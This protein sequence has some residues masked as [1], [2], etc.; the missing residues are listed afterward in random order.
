VGM[1]ERLYGLAMAVWF[2]RYKEV[3]ERNV[4]VINTGDRMWIMSPIWAKHMDVD[5]DVIWRW[6][7]KW[8]V[9]VWAVVESIIDVIKICKGREPELKEIKRVIEEDKTICE[10][11]RDVL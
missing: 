3:V 4:I 5:S 9:P 10:E 11:V 2:K 1:R 7:M 8:G 6:G